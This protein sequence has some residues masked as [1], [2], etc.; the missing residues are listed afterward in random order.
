MEIIMKP[1][2]RKTVAVV[3]AIVLVGAMLA[4]LIAAI[5]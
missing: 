3:I 2:T 5:V 1:S 4:S